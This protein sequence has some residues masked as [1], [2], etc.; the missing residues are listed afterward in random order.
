[1][2]LEEIQ[3]VMSMLYTAK[4]LYDVGRSDILDIVDG[5][6]NP[7]DCISFGYEAVQYVCDRVYINYSERRDLYTYYFSDESIMRYYKLCRE[8]TRLKG[9]ALRDN[10][11]MKRAEE[12]VSENL[13]SGCYYCYYRLQTKINHAWS[14]G[15]V[16]YFS[17]DFYEFDA[18]VYRMAEVKDFFI[19]EA[20][21]LQKE[22]DRLSLLKLKQE[23]A[24]PVVQTVPVQVKPVL[25]RIAA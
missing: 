8:Y 20:E 21:T 19:H 25:E 11:Y 5:E 6:I 2:N 9:I 3:Y 18:L 24:K 17:S 7:D 15:I 12:N 1:M 14:A 4:K 23:K 22:V 13:D 10:S 16:F